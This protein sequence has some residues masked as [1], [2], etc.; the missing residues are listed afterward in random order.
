MSTNQTNIEGSNSFETNL[1]KWVEQEKKAV[2]LMNTIGHL[3]YDKA[4]E[5]VLFRHHLVDSSVSEILKKHKNVQNY[6]CLL[7][8]SPS[9]RD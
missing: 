5:L 2:G 3:L 4:V 6:T 1:N 8:T 7:Y 9:P